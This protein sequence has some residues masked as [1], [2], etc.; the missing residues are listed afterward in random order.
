MLKIFEFIKSI[1][2]S[3]NFL[4]YCGD[5]LAVSMP[6]GFLIYL[7]KGEKKSFITQ[8]IIVYSFTYILKLIINS[9]RP[10]LSNNFSFPSAHMVSS[11]MVAHYYNTYTNSNNLSIVYALYLLSFF[12]GYTRIKFNKHFRRDIIGA[13]LIVFALNPFKP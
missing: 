9:P 1:V 5:I 8:F 2:R 6:I 13:I 4:K 3:K 11:F 12:V 10:D 7:P